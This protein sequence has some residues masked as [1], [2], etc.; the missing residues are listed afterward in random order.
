[1]WHRSSLKEEGCRDRAAHRGT[2]SQ[3]IWRR[4]FS[5]DLSFARTTSVAHA[6][7]IGAC[8][9][10]LGFVCHFVRRFSVVWSDSPA[11]SHRRFNGICLDRTAPPGHLIRID[12]RGDFYIENSEDCSYDYL[13]FRDGPWGFSPL[14][15]RYCGRQHPPTVLSTG[16]WMWIAF[17]SDDSIEYTGFHAVY[18][19][20]DP[21]DG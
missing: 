4:A 2:T 10:L 20:I 19:M 3:P 1:V 16:R 8:A 17:K 14:L 13:E 15:G 21:S 5:G 18:E 9:A 7:A 11:C 6:E 12:F